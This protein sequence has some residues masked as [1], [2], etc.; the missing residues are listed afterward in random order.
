[1]HN[2]NCRV[3]VQYYTDPES[4]SK[5]ADGKFTFTGNLTE[6]GKE[7][8]KVLVVKY[9]ASCFR[10]CNLIPFMDILY[11]MKYNLQLCITFR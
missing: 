5:G 8:E 4:V 10:L 11:I 3:Q 1:M 6:P 9:R 7:T 2:L